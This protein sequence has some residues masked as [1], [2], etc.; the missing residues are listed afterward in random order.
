MQAPNAPERQPPPAIPLSNDAEHRHADH[1]DK[2][3]A[4]DAAKKPRPSTLDGLTLYT[5]NC[6]SCHGP[7]SESSIQDPSLA[8][9]KAALLSVEL[10]KL[11]KI[12]LT[13]VELDAISF[14]ITEQRGGS[15]AHPI[16]NVFDPAPVDSESLSGFELYQKNC[17]AC[18]GMLA[19][20]AV[21]GR[22][23]SSIKAALSSVAQMS[24]IRLS[25]DQIAGIAEALRDD[26]LGVF[27]C[28]ENQDDFV[29]DA[30]RPLS[31]LEY[32]N[33]IEELFG[34]Y[35]VMERIQVEL[36]AIPQ[37]SARQKFDTVGLSLSQ[38]HF[39]QYQ[40]VAQ[41]VADQVFEQSDFV[42]EAFAQPECLQGDRLNEACF[43][44]FLNRYAYKILR[45][46]VESSDRRVF[47]VIR[48]AEADAP[49]LTAKQ[50]GKA[51]L[52]AMLLSPDF[53]FHLY[54]RG[55][56]VA[57]RS[58]LVSLTSYEL[59]SRLSYALWAS[60]PDDSLYAKAKSGSILNDE[61]F[62]N[63]VARLLSD[64]KAKRHNAAF[65]DQWLGLSPNAQ[66]N[67]SSEIL[68]G[69]VVDPKL[70]AEVS[71]EAQDFVNWIVFEQK[72]GLNELLSSDF[73]RPRSELYRQIIA[74]MQ[75]AK[76]ERPGLLWRLI[77]SHSTFQSERNLIHSG[78]IIREN[79]LCET[80]PLPT[81]EATAELISD[82]TNESLRSIS[83]RQEIERK[84]SAAACSGCHAKINPL[85]FASANAYDS[86]GRFIEEELRIG[87][88]GQINR[89]PVDTLVQDPHI[90]NPGE[91]A[92]QGP[93]QL[94]NALADSK[95]LSACLVQSRYSAMM[96]RR[97]QPQRNQD[98]CSLQRGFDKIYNGAS[99]IEML[100]ALFGPEFKLRKPA[101]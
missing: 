87:E 100:T 52:K 22:S 97:I 58:D 40:Q 7:I 70:L 73:S 92:V 85:A 86:I 34:R 98:A 44:Y 4:E 81:D 24:A 36:A 76:V 26:K 42:V 17:Q 71:A 6:Q 80:L 23:S 83:A 94:A 31:R 55:D 50:Q 49:A 43:D 66:I 37:Q 27:G 68:A 56:A 53:V 30:I 2:Q 11:S 91:Q 72:A 29:A 84:T 46:P 89:F 62:K 18:H 15:P 19:D 35:G 3:K 51:L 93:M 12:E 88:N 59:A 57:G 96:G 77:L 39:R 38:D 28:E 20:S 25:D 41:K 21:K 67:I 101:R 78:K 10:M 54:I 9:I 32:K 8:S 14:A 61:T 69:L 5:N 1:P 33:T 99:Y 45:R 75:S 63:E 95:R 74:G 13:D 48:T 82:A 90:D 64:D 65:F 79:L 60:P 16:D 47:E